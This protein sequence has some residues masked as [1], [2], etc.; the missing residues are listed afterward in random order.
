MAGRLSHRTFTDH[1]IAIH[2]TVFFPSGYDAN[3]Q[4]PVIVAFHGSGE[5]GEDGQRQLTTGM[6]KLVQA[7]SETFP[8]VVVLP[9]VP[10]RG[11]IFGWVS[12]M[13]RLIDAAVH[14]VNGDPS[15][16]YLTGIS[17]GGILAYNL[18]YDYPDRFAALIPVSAYV[19]LPD[20]ERGTKMPKADAYAREAQALRGTPVWIFHGERDTNI[21]VAEARELEATFKAAGVPV[22][23]TELRDMPH[24]SWDQAYQ[25][26]ELWSWVL[27]QHR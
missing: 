20:P 18:A 27:K 6:G 23:Y 21:P 26:P 3:V 22:R 24:Q 15:R 7:Q 2:Y 11:Q 19:V 9:Q 14:E 16:V 25:T 5:K 10:A 4:W 17:F 12:P 8:A 13:M 1:G